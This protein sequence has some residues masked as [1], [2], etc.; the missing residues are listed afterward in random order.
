MKIVYLAGPYRATTEYGVHRNIQRA[1]ALALEVWRL[2]AA[3][4]C[5]HKN[6]AYFGGALPDA[7]W[8]EGYLEL[9]RRCDALLVMPGSAAS[10]GTAAETKEANARGIPV[11]WSLA[12]LSEWLRGQSEP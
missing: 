3:C 5:P 8:L 10:V 6:T 7:V 12:D 9:L 2:G 11:F 4:L 1:E